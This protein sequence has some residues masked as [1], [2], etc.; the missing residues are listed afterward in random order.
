MTKP[1]SFK[2]AMSLDKTTKNALRYQEAEVKGQAPRIG[3]LYIQ[4]HALPDSPDTISV[5]VEVQ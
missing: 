1:V 4:K 2:V 3:Q 5:T